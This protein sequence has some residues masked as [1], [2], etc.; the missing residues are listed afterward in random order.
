MENIEHMAKNSLDA[1]ARDNLSPEGRRSMTVDIVTGSAGLVALAAG[2]LLGR[3][4][5]GREGIVALIYT[6]GIVIELIPIYAVAV[7]GIF[8]KNLTNSM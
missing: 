2:L 8:G 7:K 4:F 6:V 1:L 5:P 3:L